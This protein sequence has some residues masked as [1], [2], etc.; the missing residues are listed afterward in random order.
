VQIVQQGS[1]IAAD[2]SRVPLHAQTICIHGDT[3]GAPEIAAA[4][5]SALRTAGVELRATGT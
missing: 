2:G 3:P 1:V 4:I 5:N